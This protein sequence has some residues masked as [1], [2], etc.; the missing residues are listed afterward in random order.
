MSVSSTS[1][2]LAKQEAQQMH[3]SHCRLNDGHYNGLFH[4]SGRKMSVQKET[5]SPKAHQ[6]TFINNLMMVTE[7]AL[8]AHEMQNR[9]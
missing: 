3:S 9:I 6:F 5:N 7:P 4:V 1:C 8:A 2:S